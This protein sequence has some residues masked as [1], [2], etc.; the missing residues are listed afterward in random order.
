[1]FDIS[2]NNLFEYLIMKGLKT[3]LKNSVAKN[4]PKAT[5]TGTRPPEFKKFLPQ[6]RNIQ[7]FGQNISDFLSFSIKFLR[8]YFQIMMIWKY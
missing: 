5:T 7:D 1:M 3:S 2:L 4:E 6:S 8:K